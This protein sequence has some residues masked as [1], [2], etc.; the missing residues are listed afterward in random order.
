MSKDI[1]QEIP[2]IGQDVIDEIDPVPIKPTPATGNPVQDMNSRVDAALEALKERGARTRRQMEVD[3]DIG[4]YVVIVFQSSEQRKAF[5]ERAGWT[6]GLGDRYIDGLQLAAKMGIE[7]RREPWRPFAPV[8][9]K[10][11]HRMLRMP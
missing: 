9:S 6:T 2:D 8:P 5:C 11:A 10:D 7:I 3:T 1:P 4:Y